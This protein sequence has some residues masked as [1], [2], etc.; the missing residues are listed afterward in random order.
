MANLAASPELLPSARAMV[1][2]E[3]IRG[4]VCVPLQS[5]GRILGTLSLGRRST[6]PFTDAEIALLEAAANQ[7]SLALDNARL[8]SATRS[9]LEELKQ[10]ETQLMEGERLS[11]VGRLAAGLVHEINNP[12][13]VILGQ[14]ELVMKELADSARGRE[15]M[16]IIMQETSRVGRLLGRVLQL[17]EPQPS[18]RRPCA[19]EEQV[20]WVAEVKRDE[21]DRDGIRIVT[22]VA[23]V[24]SVYADQDQIRQVLLNL[25]QNAQQAMAKHPGQRVLTLLVSESDGRV[26]VEV[27]DTGPG[28]PPEVLPRIF[29]A[30]FTTKTAGD[31]T[32]LGLWVS[33]GIVE[34]HQ[35]RL[36]AESRPEGG[37][38]FIIELPYRKGS[39]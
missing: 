33:Y 16:R 29:D 11:T 13:T 32:G 17:S 1:E 26:R 3:G 14:A 38:A 30:F 9:Q 39:R 12:L 36:R 20:R 10:A 31:G 24:P 37:A 34:Q 18:E 21:L 5:R 27:R 28:I 19:L 6:E 25:V 4:F 35:G 22:E 7:I 15:R 2:R 23:T 8:Y